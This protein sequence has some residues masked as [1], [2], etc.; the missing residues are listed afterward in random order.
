MSL[1]M[2]LTLMLAIVLVAAGVTAPSAVAAL[3]DTLQADLSHPA[4]AVP[5]VQVTVGAPIGEEVT[6]GGSTVVMRVT[7]RPPA[8]KPL[9]GILTPPGEKPLFT[10]TMP[11][12]VYW[13]FAVLQAAKHALAGGAQLDAISVTHNMIG[14]PARPTPTIIERLEGFDPPPTPLTV[15]SLA[16]LKARIRNALPE[17]ATGSSIT[18]EEDY[19]GERVVAVKAQ[20]PPSGF[21][22]VSVRSLFRTLA[23]QQ[24]DLAPEG[25]RIGRVFLEIAN[26]T[27]G[28]PLLAAAADP[29]LGTAL[30]WTSPLVRVLVGHLGT[31]DDLLTDPKDT[32]DDAAADLPAPLNETKESVDEQYEDLA[33]TLGTTLGTAKTIVF[34]V[35]PPS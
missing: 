16:E 8:G 18:V 6:L 31:G 17:W 33:G 24:A 10:T 13:D 19:A 7:M 4:S 20:L 35:L 28:D 9:T 27:T 11:K 29:S 1:P 5:D 34:G 32:L 21:R 23:R 25:A 15:M 14:E 26:P 30:Y 12:L 2:R 3:A 22:V